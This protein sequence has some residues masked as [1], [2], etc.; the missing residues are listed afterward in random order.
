MQSYVI[1]RRS[2]CSPSFSVIRG[3]LGPVHLELSSSTVIKRA[4]TLIRTYT[5]YLFCIILRVECDYFPKRVG[6]EL[7][8]IS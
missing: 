7:V 2:S 6:S 8:Y 4:L 3:N 1:N 5:V